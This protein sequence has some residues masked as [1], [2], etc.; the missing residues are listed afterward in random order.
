MFLNVSARAFMINHN[1][2]GY[3]YMEAH[4]GLKGR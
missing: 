1:L 3:A 2:N 4:Y